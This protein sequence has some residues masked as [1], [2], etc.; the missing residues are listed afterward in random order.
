MP[1]DHETH[2]PVPDWHSHA[3]SGASLG[4]AGRGSH[5][6]AP[7]TMF[8]ELPADHRQ[9]DAMADYRISYFYCRGSCPY[10]KRKAE[11]SEKNRVALWHAMGPSFSLVFVN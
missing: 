7:D 2:D 5:S 9:I 11:V 4:L 10:R 8:C 3:A 1:Y 6:R